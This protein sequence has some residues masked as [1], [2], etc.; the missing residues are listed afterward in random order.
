VNGTRYFLYS[1]FD[2]K[3]ARTNGYEENIVKI[4]GVMGVCVGV[5]V[6]VCARARAR[7]LRARMC[8]NIT[9]QYPQSLCL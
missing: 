6:G 8:V 4:Q 5:C 1:T 9:N 2:L 7:A 3:S